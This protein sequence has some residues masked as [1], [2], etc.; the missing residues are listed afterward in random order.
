V[1]DLPILHSVMKY[2]S[3]QVK[4]SLKI[5]MTREKVDAFY[6]W[7]N[8][9]IIWTSAIEYGLMPDIPG[10]V[11]KNRRGDC[12]MQTLLFLSLCR[13]EGIP[14]RWQSG[15]MLHPGHVNLHDWS[16]VYIEPEGWVPVDVSFKLQPSENQKV[17]EFYISG[18]DS[19]RLI[20]NKDYGTPL[21]PP[22]KFPRSEPLDFQRGEVE[23]KG[24]NIYFNKWKY[25]MEVSY[26]IP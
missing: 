14:A 4:L 5:W 24:G 19:Y 2:K 21:Y 23:W 6:R 1:K 12:G 15:W 10:Y 26:I 25:D 8:D 11:L 22:K 7:I 9:N 18:I 20:V 13:Y 16:E 17:S 3:L